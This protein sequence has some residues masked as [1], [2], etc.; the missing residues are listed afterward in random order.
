MAILLPLLSAKRLWIEA[1][2][3][4]KLITVLL[5]TGTSDCLC[6]SALPH[7]CARL[8]QQLQ[9][10]S[11]KSR[12]SIF[13]L[14]QCQSR[15]LPAT[16]L[17]SLWRGLGGLPAPTCVLIATST[18]TIA[19]RATQVQLIH[20]LGRGKGLYYEGWGCH[21]LV[22]VCMVV[23]GYSCCLCSFWKLLFTEN[24]FYS[25]RG[26]GGFLG[27]LWLKRHCS[28]WIHTKDDF[29]LRTEQLVSATV[30]GARLHQA[31]REMCSSL[32]TSCCGCPSRTL[33]I[34]KV[35]LPFL[36][37]PLHQCLGILS[38]TVFQPL[39]GV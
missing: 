2:C 22:C 32:S 17:H 35:N 11:S 10:P 3:W 20:C 14:P 28:C 1:L 24:A 18:V 23:W 30:A 4:L 19:G 27:S 25:L 8:C 36:Q 9:W 12:H 7:G 33:A 5:S 38:F 15:E 13:Q 21:S 26:V 39:G 31:V 6:S 37:V 29:L 34:D 16:T